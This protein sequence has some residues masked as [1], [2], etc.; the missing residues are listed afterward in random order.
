MSIHL[1]VENFHETAATPGPSMVNRPPVL[2]I[3]GNNESKGYDDTRRMLKPA[4]IDDHEVELTPLVTYTKGTCSSGAS[5]TLVAWIA[6][7]II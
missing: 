3:P 4:P 1:N 6:A 5:S 2:V 7:A